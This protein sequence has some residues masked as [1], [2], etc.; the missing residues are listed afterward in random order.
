MD[1]DAEASSAGGPV[2]LVRP[3]TQGMDRTSAASVRAAGEAA[4]STT[5][6]SDLA[7]LKYKANKPLT[8]PAR[9]AA[10]QG[11]TGAGLTGAHGASPVMQEVKP[12]A[13]M[14]AAAS[15]PP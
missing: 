8:S 14:M 11:E 12:R 15:G 7:H 6:A 3:H 9:T 13:R 5:R 1:A 2:L 10:S 4:A